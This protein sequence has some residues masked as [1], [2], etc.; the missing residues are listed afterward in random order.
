M[1]NPRCTGYRQ[2]LLSGAIRDRSPDLLGRRQVV[3]Q[4][5]LIPSFAGSNPAAPATQS[6]HIYR[7]AGASWEVPCFPWVS[8]HLKRYITLQTLH[9]GPILAIATIDSPPPNFTVW[10]GVDGALYGQD[11]IG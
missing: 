7:Y 9:I 6:L 2:R 11:T 8:R 3:R 5:V 10:L 4:R 1:Q